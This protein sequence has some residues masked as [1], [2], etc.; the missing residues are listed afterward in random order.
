MEP[1]STARP[2]GFDEDDLQIQED[3]VRRQVRRYSAQLAAAIEQMI[4]GFM[5]FEFAFDFE[6]YSA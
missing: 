4:D 3:E 2:Q 5:T 1:R 6:A